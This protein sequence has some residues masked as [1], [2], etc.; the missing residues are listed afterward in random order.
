MKAEH[1]R[2]YLG[3]GL[4]IGLVG[5]S[6]NALLFQHERHPAPLFGSPPQPASSATRAQAAS[7]APRAPS[8]EREASASQSGAAIPPSR[9]GDAADASPSTA[10]DPITD[11]L[12]GET[13]VDGAHLIM[14]AQTALAKLGYPVKPDGN[15]GLA[16]QQALRDFERTHGLPPSTEITPK[17]LKQLTQAA[18]AVA[19]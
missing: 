18:R 3:A 6:V 4:A 5:I 13:R 1:L 7:P 14:A 19:R 2:L 15:D 10:S 9:P 17:L 11:L 16:T 12:R 8:A